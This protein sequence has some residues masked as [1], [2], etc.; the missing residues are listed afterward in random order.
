MPTPA[1][2]EGIRRE[3][4]P[5]LIK[6]R[7]GKRHADGSVSVR[8]F[9]GATV[10]LYGPYWELGGGTYRLDLRFGA[11]RARHADEAFVGIEIVAQNQTLLF[12][13][14]FSVSDLPDGAA[15]IV[16]RIDETLCVGGEDPKVEFRILHFGAASFTIDRM[17]L[18]PEDDVPSACL[19]PFRWRLSPRARR[20]WRW[21]AVKDVLLSGRLP[22]WSSFTLQ[23]HPWLRLPV[24]RYKLR[25]RVPGAH[26]GSAI[27]AVATVGGR[28]VADQTFVRADGVCSLSLVLP[29]P[30]LLGY[31]GW[32]LFELQVTG[33]NKRDLNDLQLD[34]LSGDSQ[35]LSVERP[36][37]V[38]DAPLRA[39]IIGNCQAE[40]LTDR[41]RRL[42]R[43]DRLQV[44]YH[45][46]GLQPNLQAQG[47]EELAAANVVL[48]QDIR[49]FET[50]PLRTALPEGAAQHRFPMLRHSVAWPFDTLN[51]MADP[52]A[53]AR[54]TTDPYFP[55]LDGVL[56]RLR[57]EIPDPEERFRSYDRL[58]MKGLP[59]VD[60]LVDLERRRL[61]S[62]DR[63]HACR[64]GAY[65]LENYRSHQLF[66]SVGH[67]GRE[68]F[69]QLLAHLHV[70][71]G[72]KWP[73]RYGDRIDPLAN[74]QVP[75]H[76]RVAERLGLRWARAS[77]KYNFRGERLTWAEYTRRY[78]RHFG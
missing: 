59:N 17:V 74:I 45:F 32:E 35:Q 14:D 12:A 27:S 42:H 5:A 39:V 72:L 25:F 9:E 10:L 57:K 2:G 54:E 34:R 61:E 58:E 23:F 43:W 22:G 76:P 8:A 70:P 44:T 40:I 13:A 67:P 69:D 50:Y 36:A 65:I 37:I 63:H 62:M 75:V 1:E 66:H 48:I 60:R 77:T 26:G 46:V 53:A 28:P 11:I 7:A 4:L 19:P 18:A 41:L 47:L 31:G 30:V 21:K 6:Q 71:L 16:F 56:G 15:S 38:G 24:G 52:V 68:L 3:V 55:N 33:A 64:L 78:I 49:D 29:Q 51:G 73:A 20:V